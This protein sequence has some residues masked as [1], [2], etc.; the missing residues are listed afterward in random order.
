MLRRE[1]KRASAGALRHDV[2]GRT[3]RRLTVQY[4]VLLLLFL[5]LF[6]AAAYS[7]IH[8]SVENEQVSKIHTMLDDELRFLQEHDGN[9]RS[10]RFT[11]EKERY[12]AVG[13][14]QAFYYLVDPHGNVVMGDESQSGLREQAL[15]ELDERSF[16]DGK[17]RVV[18]FQTQSRFFHKREGNSQA[19]YLMASRK[20]MDAGRD[21]GTLYV[22]IDISPQKE[23]LS[24]AALVLGGLTLLFA[25]ACIYVSHLMS[26]RAMVPIAQSLARQ[27]EFVADASHELRTPLSVLLASIEAMGMRKRSPEAGEDR[28]EKQTLGYMKDEV[29]GMTRLVGDLLYLA[30]SDSGAEPLRLERFDFRASAERTLSGMAPV[31]EAK[32]ISLQFEAPETLPVYGD[33]QRLVQLLVIL[34]DNAVKYSQPSM[35]VRV[36]LALGKQR[37]QHSL[38]LTV[39]DRGIGIPLEEQGRIFERFYREDRARTRQQGGHGLGL[40]IAKRIV[41]A[42]SGSIHVE[43]EPGRGSAFTVVLPMRADG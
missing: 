41:D 9:T 2:I 31:L 7:L 32:Q 10:E 11:E 42:C 33:E 20:V 37:H 25:V 36:R 21:M 15:R 16:A 22:G 43:S 5:G 4:S 38:V 30:R 27:R 18:E 26:K 1:E 28:F 35:P 24:K 17:T 23:M 14:D 8:E 40:A 19:P 34:V 39:A 13:A 12:F 6:A 3:Q 29:K